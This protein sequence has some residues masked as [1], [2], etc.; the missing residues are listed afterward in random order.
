MAIV[1]FSCLTATAQT[2][3]LDK[4]PQPKRDSILIDIAKSAILKYTEGYDR[5]DIP[6]I[7]DLGPF[8]TKYKDEEQ[9][10]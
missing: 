10:K 7:K 3:N 4:L 9:E 6:T 8:R 2:I 1:L 5:G